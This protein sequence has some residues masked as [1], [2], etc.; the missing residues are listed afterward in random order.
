MIIAQW[1]FSALVKPLDET[2]G[3]IYSPAHD[4]AH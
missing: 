1:L 3:A 2:P 4:R